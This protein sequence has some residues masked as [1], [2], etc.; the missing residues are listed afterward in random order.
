MFIEKQYKNFQKI[1]NIDN[2]SDFHRI[3]SKNYETKMFEKSVRRE[4]NNIF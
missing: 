3:L 1:W 2:F 4:K